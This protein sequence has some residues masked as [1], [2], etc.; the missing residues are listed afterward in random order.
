MGGV[1]NKELSEAPKRILSGHSSI[2]N[3]SP[4]VVLCLFINASN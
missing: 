4:D 2:L 3:D 1:G